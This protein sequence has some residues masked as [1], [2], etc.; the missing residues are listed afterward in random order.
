MTTLFSNRLCKTTVD[1]CVHRRESS[2]VEFATYRTNH[3]QFFIIISNH[4]RRRS[5]RRRRRRSEFIG[6]GRFRFFLT[7]IITVMIG[8][9]RFLGIGSALRAGRHR[10]KARVK[11]VARELTV[12]G[13]R[14]WP[15]F[16]NIDGPHLRSV[17]S[18]MKMSYYKV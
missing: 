5:T 13:G 14:E 18:G 16:E 7:G 17:F 6:F 10:R 2:C 8:S 11:F 9:R 15:A 3:L 12:S 4:V 1:V